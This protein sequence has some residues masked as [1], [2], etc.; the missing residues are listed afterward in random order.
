[1]KQGYAT[2]FA[3]IAIVSMALILISAKWTHSAWVYAR[4][5][6]IPLFELVK[7]G[8]EVFIR[9]TCP[10]LIDVGKTN[11]HLL[12]ERGIDRMHC[13]ADATVFV[14]ATPCENSFFKRSGEE[15]RYVRSF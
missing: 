10:H 11:L 6:A 4:G 13:V 3:L 1:M 15:M 8:E 2:I 7:D 9:G 14:D 5:R 12:V